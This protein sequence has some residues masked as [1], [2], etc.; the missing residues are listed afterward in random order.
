MLFIE[1]KRFYR[2]DSDRT[3]GRAFI[4]NEPT[5]LKFPEHWQK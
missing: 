4:L 1:F 3:S 2:G 5:Q